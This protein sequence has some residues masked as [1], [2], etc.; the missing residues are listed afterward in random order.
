[1]I[2]EGK[3]HQTNI[4]MCHIHFTQPHTHINKS[5]YTPQ[6]ALVHIMKSKK[7]TQE[8]KVCLVQEGNFPANQMCVKI[9]VV[10]FGY[11]T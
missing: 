6:V 1:M 2:D 10:V 8:G 11:L 3:H 5:T 9:E 4:G 7:T